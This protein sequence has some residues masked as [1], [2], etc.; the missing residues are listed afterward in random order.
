[1]T[2]VHEAGQAGRRAARAGRDGAERAAHSDTLERIARLG[3]VCRGA[4]YVFIGVI[5]AQVALGTS[6]GQRADQQGALQEL[7]GRSYGPVL[8]WLAALGF[9]GYAIWRFSEAAIG[10]RAEQGGKRVLERV[11]SGVKGVVYAGFAVTAATIASSGSSDS[12]SESTT[13][14]IMAESGGR[15]LI[16]AIGVAVVGAGVFM[17]VQAIRTDFAD[18]LETGR[19]SPRLRSVALGLGKAGYAARGVVFA[20]AGGLVVQAAVTFDPEKAR[21]LD[22]ALRSLA[23]APA[24]TVLLLVIAAG[25]VAFGAYSIIESRYRRVDPG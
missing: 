21:G 1:M 20:I 13:A 17:L 18:E 25:L 2:D 3:F 5:A 4:V 23:T 6:G 11:I 12:S 19:M 10:H 16:G 15:W 24:G 8:L 22:L 9:A 14:T 7:V